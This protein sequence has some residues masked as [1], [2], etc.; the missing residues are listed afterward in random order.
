M[1]Q[2]WRKRALLGGIGDRRLS[3]EQHEGD[4]RGHCPARDRQFIGIAT[5][6]TALTARW[7]NAGDSCAVPAAV[8]ACDGPSSV[9]DA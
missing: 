2:H 3:A 8:R 7:E 4:T 9:P 1:D 6:T 5:L